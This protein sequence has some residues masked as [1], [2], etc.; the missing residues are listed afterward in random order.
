MVFEWCTCQMPVTSGRQQKKLGKLFMIMCHVFDSVFFNL[1]QFAELSILFIWRNL[2][3]QYIA[4]YSI[5]KLPIEIVGT[6]ELHRTQVEKH[7]CKPKI[8][9][10]WI[11]LLFGS[12][13]KREIYF[14]VGTLFRLQKCDLCLK[15]T[16]SWLTWYQLSLSGI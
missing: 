6:S 10:P 14:Q 2:S 5:L 13:L 16:T 1:F 15:L 9:T 11:K 7:C 3:I 12:I 8:D 4:I